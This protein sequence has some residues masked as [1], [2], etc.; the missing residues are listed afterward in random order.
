[1]LTTL[2]ERGKANVL[3]FCKPILGGKSAI[4]PTADSMVYAELNGTMQWLL[5]TG[6]KDNCFLLRRILHQKRVTGR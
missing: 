1:M 2:A 3:D 5:R 6:R 4:L